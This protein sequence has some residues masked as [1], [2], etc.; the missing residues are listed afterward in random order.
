MAL[1]ST[2]CSMSKFV[3]MVDTEEAKER[4]AASAMGR[5]DNMM[6][7]SERGLANDRERLVVQR[8]IYRKGSQLR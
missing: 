3:G 2:A 1:G 8:L 7:E 5:L 4:R 6:K